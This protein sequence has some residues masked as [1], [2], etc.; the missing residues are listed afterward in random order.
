MTLDDIEKLAGD[1]LASCTDAGQNN[2]LARAVLAMLP[3]VRLAEKYAAADLVAQ[4]IKAAIDTLR[5][6]LEPT[7]A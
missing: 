1:T 2:R 6:A 5:A 4:D 7:D 3:V